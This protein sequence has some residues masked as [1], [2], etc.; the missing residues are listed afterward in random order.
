LLIPPASEDGIDLTVAAIKTCLQSPHVKHLLLLSRICCSPAPAS[1]SV[2]PNTETPPPFLQDQFQRLETHFQERCEEAARAHTVIRIP[3]L[4]HPAE[5]S[6]LPA[7]ALSSKILSL[8]ESQRLYSSLFLS[9]TL[10]QKHPFVTL[11]DLGRGI[12]Q[13][14]TSASAST[15][16]SEAKPMKERYL[17]YSSLESDAEVLSLIAQLWGDGISYQ[18]V[19]FPPP[20]LPPDVISRPIKRNDSSHWRL[21]LFPSGLSGITSSCS[22]PST[23]ETPPVGEFRRATSL[24]CYN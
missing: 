7:S 12:A 10:T 9:A 23:R 6:R 14:V 21:C 15:S 5:P 19:L 22:M 2:P 17:L 11:E 20:F 24:L 13:L 16:S 3:L 18:P 8:L 1:A 4:C